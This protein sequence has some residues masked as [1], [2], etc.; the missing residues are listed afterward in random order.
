MPRVPRVV[1]GADVGGSSSGRDVRSGVPSM[2]HVKDEGVF[3]API[4][5]IWKFLIDPSATA[6]HHRAIRGMTTI[7]QEGTAVTQEVEFLNPDGKT[8]RKETWRFVFNPPKGF[9]MES[10]GGASKRTKHAHHYTPSGNK[11]RV[12][13][14]GDFAIQGMDDAATRAAVLAFL[15]EVFDE[16]QAALTAHS[17]DRSVRRAEGALG[18]RI[19]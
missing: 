1:F 3:D 18:A 14:E 4:D 2:V 6:H 13:G 17:F 15:A 11:T 12:E 19:S 16:D 8:T 10:L 5:T 7:R 9:E